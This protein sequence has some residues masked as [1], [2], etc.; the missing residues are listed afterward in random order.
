MSSFQQNYDHSKRR[1][2]RSTTTKESA[3]A[4]VKNQASVIPNPILNPYAK[5]K[6]LG[7]C[8]STCVVIFENN[9][10]S[11]LPGVQENH[12]IP[13]GSVNGRAD[14]GMITPSLL[15]FVY[16]VD[17]ATRY[18]QNFPKNKLSAPNVQPVGF[19]YCCLALS[20]TSSCKWKMDVQS[21][22]NDESFCHACLM[23][24]EKLCGRTGNKNKQCKKSVIMA[25]ANW[26]FRGIG[27]RGMKEEYDNQ[28]GKGKY[29]A[30]IPLPLAPTSHNIG[31]CIDWI[32]NNQ[33][34]YW[35]TVHTVLKK[36]S[37]KTANHTGGPLG[38]KTPSTSVIL[39]ASMARPLVVSISI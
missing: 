5:K 35:N 8:N 32:K 14:F 1:T 34:D 11:D 39:A 17:K 20:K 6:K 21:Y 24:K 22:K 27:Y 7:L 29:F 28:F 12:F 4:P 19:C 33:D 36:S 26:S 2:I 18:L 9:Q 38:D 23:D 15:K 10:V 3:S 25:I 37:H 13:K 31:P 16:S 30:D